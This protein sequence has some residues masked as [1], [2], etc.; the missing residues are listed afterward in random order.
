MF[1]D[2]PTRAIIDFALSQ[3]EPYY[4]LR[5]L[6]RAG[7]LAAVYRPLTGGGAV[8]SDFNEIFPCSKTRKISVEVETV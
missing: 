2:K 6:I 5:S 7:Q 4:A 8:E 3:Q 1:Q